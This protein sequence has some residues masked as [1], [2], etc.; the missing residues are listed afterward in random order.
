MASPIHAAKRALRTELK[1]RIAALSDIEKLRQTQAVTHKLLSHERYKR[2]QRIAVFLSMADEIQ[3]GSIL[4][5]IF[6]QGKACFIPR[7]RPRSTH[8]DMVR[9]NSLEEI[10]QLPKTTWNISQPGAEDSREDALSTGG[11][12]LVLMPG[13]GFDKEGHRLGRGKGYYDTFLNRYNQSLASKP[14][15]I[16]LTFRE[17][18]C[19]AIPVS[20]QDFQ[21]DEII[22]SDI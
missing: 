19:D 15:T 4:Q 20:D 13:L 10:Q 11:L 16:A 8:M 14:Y 3:T 9:L 6:Q 2:A 1:E 18:L 21:I 22:C 17:Q 5:D 12:D 7:Y